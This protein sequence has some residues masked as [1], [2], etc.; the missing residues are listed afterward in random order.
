MHSQNLIVQYLTLLLCH[1]NMAHR[2]Y[3]RNLR[4]FEAVI[5]PGILNFAI[6]HVS[7]STAQRRILYCAV[8]AYWEAAR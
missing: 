6:P 3:Y 1:H 5:F 7:A 2:E 4:P 8:S